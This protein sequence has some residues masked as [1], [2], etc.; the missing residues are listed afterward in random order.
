[1]P[2]RHSLTDNVSVALMAG[3]GQKRSAVQFR[4]YLM[5]NSNQP[6]GKTVAT[7]PSKSVNHHFRGEGKLMVWLV[8]GVPFMLTVG[9]FLFGYVIHTFSGR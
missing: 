1:M 8:V 6:Q 7:D 2:S 5:T 3:T 9:A 4:K